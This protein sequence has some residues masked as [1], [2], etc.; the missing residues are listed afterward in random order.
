M[1]LPPA[2]ASRSFVAVVAAVVVVCGLAAPARAARKP[3]S[4]KP[5][6]VVLVHTQ[7]EV[8][9]PWSPRLRSAAQK[10]QDRNWVDPPAVTLDEVQLVLGCATWGVA[11]AAQVAGMTGAQNALVID[12]VRKGPGAT[13]VIEAVSADGTVAA[14]PERVELAGVDDDGLKLAEAWVAG[15]VKGARPTVLLVSADLEGTEV[16]VDN[17]PR[18]KTPLMLIDTIPAGEHTLLLRREGRA[19][20]SRT[21]QVVAGMNRE[22]GVLSAGG[23]AMK[24]EP[25]V[26]TEPVRV[27]EAPPAETPPP[28]GGVPPMVFV[29]WGLTGVGAVAAVVVGVVGTV[30][31][32]DV[33]DYHNGIDPETNR[34]R[35]DYQSTFGGAVAPDQ[36]ANFFADTFGVA[37][38]AADE[39]PEAYGVRLADGV[40]AK[41]NAAAGLFVGAGIGALLAGTGAF[42]AL[43][44]SPGE[45]ADA[46]VVT[47]PAR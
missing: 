26:G 3:A 13:V 39:E 14:E 34:V 28:A 38:Q 45:D 41:Q 30:W 27:L 16:V 19:P 29:G 18:G 46:S 32:I 40:T 42:L 47:L 44:A 5:G 10:A 37:P 8:P 6:W 12:I 2:C 7:G 9:A 31:Q 20:L 43:S 24:S 35:R 15:A 36:R 11:C 22:H 25:V 1:K 17:V 4:K 21:I 23:P 33:T